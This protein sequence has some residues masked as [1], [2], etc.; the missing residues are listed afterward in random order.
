MTITDKL[1]KISKDEY[2][3]SYTEHCLEQYKLFVESTNQI[4][5][6]RLSANSF[7]LTI[8]T[9]I[10]GLTGYIHLGDEKFVNG[11]LDSN[12]KANQNADQIKLSVFKS[13]IHVLKSPVLILILTYFLLGSF[14]K[15]TFYAF[16]VEFPVASAIPQ[17][18]VAPFWLLDTGQS[19]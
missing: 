15:N 19:S 12:V 11:H 1:F 8:N 16:A 13:H 18:S 6:R 4:S 5:N 7:F 3:E 10:I 2:G 14:A 9:A 17:V